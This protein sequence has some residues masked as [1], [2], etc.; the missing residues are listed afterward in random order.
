MYQNYDS[1]C[2][3]SGAWAMKNDFVIQNFD[4]ITKNFNY[5]KVLIKI[6]PIISSI[7]LSNSGWSQQNL[8]T[9]QIKIGEFLWEKKN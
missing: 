2:S 9:D 8:S 6:F 4:K 3:F 7:Y 5:I 1:V